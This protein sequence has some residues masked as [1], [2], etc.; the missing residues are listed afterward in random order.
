MTWETAG[1]IAVLGPAGAY[2]GA[3]GA[4]KSGVSGKMAPSPT[5]GPSPTTVMAAQRA[6]K[7][8]EALLKKRRAT[9]MGGGAL[10]LQ[11]HQLGT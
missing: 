11:T 4:S 10:N 1:Y 8:H 5:M 9:V 7:D 6:E 3:A 2:A